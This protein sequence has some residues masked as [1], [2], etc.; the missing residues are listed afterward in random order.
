MWFHSPSVRLMLGHLMMVFSFAW[1]VRLMVDTPIAPFVWM[2]MVFV[3]AFYDGHISGHGGAWARWIP[4]VLK[5]RVGV[6][7]WHRAHTLGHHIE[8]FPHRT[9]TKPQY[10][11]NRH[12]LNGLTDL[13]AYGCHALVYCVIGAKLAQISWNLSQWIAWLACA[14]LTVYLEEFVHRHI[15]IEGS[16][17]ERSTLFLWLR[18]CHR[19]H[20][21]WPYAYN[22]AITGLWMD[23]L[24]RRFRSPKNSALSPGISLT[25]TR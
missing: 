8:G 11:Q 24:S 10:S 7:R 12:S 20:H 14:F 3:R 23:M 19:E 21:K 16:W 15:H 1:I 4:N 13:V 2:W 6:P 18:E 25:C 22:F 9:F 17:M 5:E